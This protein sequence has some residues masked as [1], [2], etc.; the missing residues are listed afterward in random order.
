MPPVEQVAQFECDDD[1]LDEFLNE[2]EATNPGDFDGPPLLV[3]DNVR[4]R[5]R[6]E[7]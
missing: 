3:M 6:R 2:S 4:R 5:W 7:V 1:Q